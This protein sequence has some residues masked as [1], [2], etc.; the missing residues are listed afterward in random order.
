MP[1]GLPSGNP[2]SGLLIDGAVQQAAQPGRQAH[3]T[4]GSTFENMG[5]IVVLVKHAGA[6]LPLVLRRSGVC[7]TA[8]PGC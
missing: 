8:Q 2:G 7:A 6:T 1:A 4:F 3:A 5:W